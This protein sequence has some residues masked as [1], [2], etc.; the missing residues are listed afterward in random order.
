MSDGLDVIV[1]D[2]DQGIAEILSELIE[3]FYTWAKGIAF[4]KLTGQ[5]PFV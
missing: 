1:L 5:Y 2:D 3:S 4:P